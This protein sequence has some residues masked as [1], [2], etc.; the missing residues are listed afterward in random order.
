MLPSGDVV[1]VGGGR[2]TGIERGTADIRRL[3]DLDTGDWRFR[4]QGQLEVPVVWTT[5]SVV[6]DSG[7]GDY[8]FVAGGREAM[9]D[10]EKIYIAK[11]LADN[12]WHRG[13][14]AEVLGV[15]RK[16]LFTKMKHYGLSEK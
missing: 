6:Q 13:N 14:A 12:Q 11:V 10:F 15:N 1:V 3:A 2:T 4:P 5:A 16:T 7:G 8:V 9:D